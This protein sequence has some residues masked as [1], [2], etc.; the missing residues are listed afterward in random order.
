MSAAPDDAEAQK[1]IEEEITKNLIDEQY[2][3][4]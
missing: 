2:N 3:F 1:M 4:V